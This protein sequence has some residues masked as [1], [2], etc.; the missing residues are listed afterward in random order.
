M[1]P[2]PIASPW[3]LEIADYVALCAAFP[4]GRVRRAHPTSRSRGPCVLQ[5]SPRG[6]SGEVGAPP[7]ACAFRIWYN[8]PVEIASAL[9]AQKT[10][11]ALAG[12][13]TL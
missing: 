3:S 2:T 10:P 12:S 4:G 6:S 1:T 11:G 9:E 5:A 13:W 8:P 7:F